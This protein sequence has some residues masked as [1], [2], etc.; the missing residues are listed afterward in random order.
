MMA[1]APRHPIPCHDFGRYQGISAEIPWNQHS[2][3][4]P[5]M[6]NVDMG[7]KRSG[8]GAMASRIGA[9]I[10]D[11]VRN[12]LRNI[13]RE[14]ANDA[15]AAR[16][17]ERRLPGMLT[18]QPESLATAAVRMDRRRLD[19]ARTTLRNA[20]DLTVLDHGDRLS[21]DEM[22]DIVARADALLDVLLVREAELERLELAE[23]RAAELQTKQKEHQRRRASKKNAAS[24]AR[25]AQGQPSTTKRSKQNRQTGARSK[26]SQQSK[27]QPRTSSNSIS[28]LYTRLD[29]LSL[30][31]RHMSASQKAALR[32]QVRAEL[33]AKKKSGVALL[34]TGS[35]SLE[36]KAAAVLAMLSD[37]L[38][39]GARSWKT[40]SGG[41]APLSSRQMI[42]RARGRVVSGGLPGLGRR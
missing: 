41:P 42:Y 31:A 11:N 6:Q 36:S 35:V 5:S 1:G 24:P 3:V 8:G 12:A 29:D 19:Q 34:R 37:N 25:R 10:P 18:L 40:P 22:L 23:Q 30:Q 2:S 17:P 32:R 28:R 20:L 16:T 4:A 21:P 38:D 14:D 15:F 9:A 26:S 27:L 33:E 13:A 39:S 7:A